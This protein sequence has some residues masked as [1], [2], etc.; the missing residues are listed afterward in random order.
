MSQNC[1]QL[2]FQLSY[3]DCDTVGIAYFAIF[4]PWM[5]RT[6]STWLFSRGIRSGQMMEQL[7]V[8]VVGLKSQC[9]YLAKC[10]VFDSLTTQLVRNRIGTTSFAVGCDFMRGTQLVAQGEIEFACRGPDHAKAALPALLIEAL[11]SLPE[12][13]P[14][15][16]R[17]AR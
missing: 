16:T 13:R 17:S 2:T 12:A 4:Y 7:G 14:C 1:Q 3:G 15:A 11:S 10:E 9:R 8:Y 5:E 6:Y